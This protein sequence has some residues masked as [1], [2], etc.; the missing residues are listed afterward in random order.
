MYVYIYVRAVCIGC[1]YREVI[2]RNGEMMGSVR[3]VNG[4]F[5]E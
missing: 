2:L 3:G 1:V 4:A 5:E